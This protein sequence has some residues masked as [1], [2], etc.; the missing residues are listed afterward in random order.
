MEGLLDGFCHYSAP[1]LP[2][3]IAL[4][5]QHAPSFLTPKTGLLVIDSISTLF[6]IAFPRISD[7]KQLARL[8]TSQDGGEQSARGSFHVK[9]HDV[10]RKW[11][12]SRRW[13]V[14]SDLMSKLTRVAA[15]S[16]LVVI[17]TSQTTT[18]VTTSIGAVLSPPLSST[19]WDAG[20]ANRIV[21]FRDN[22]SVQDHDQTPNTNDVEEVSKSSAKIRFAGVLKAGEIFH[23]KS[24]TGHVIPFFISEVRYLDHGRRDHILTLCLSLD[25]AKLKASCSLSK[26]SFLFPS[27]EARR[28]Q[29]SNA[30]AL[31]LQTRNLRTTPILELKI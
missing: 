3:L 29:S 21:L 7:N 9:Q 25:F 31:K 17:L 28:N 13:A 27:K 10:A 26:H 12:S 22:Y 15:L 14:M 19:A 20:L 23:R 2:H 24:C 4:L 8:R 5:V 30:N 16:N 6:T 11:A 18:R 1:T